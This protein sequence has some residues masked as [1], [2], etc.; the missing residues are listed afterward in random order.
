LKSGNPVMPFNISLEK[1]WVMGSWDHFLVPK[2]FSRALLSIGTPIYIDSKTSEEEIQRIEGQIQ[3]ALD[4]LRNHGDSH[5]GG[6][7]ER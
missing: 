4:E 2:P 6:D 7:P 3:G 5:W 1:K